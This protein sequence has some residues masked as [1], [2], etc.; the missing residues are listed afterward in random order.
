MRGEKYKIRHDADNI[1]ATEV[2]KKQS[3]AGAIKAE[4]KMGW[5]CQKP[6]NRQIIRR[7]I[8]LF[9]K[10]NKI[11]I[12]KTFENMESLNYQKRKQNTRTK[13]PSQIK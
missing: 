7:C 8:R 6:N 9:E 1:P 11:I 12:E 3:V 13:E 4:M 10:K 5:V 2:I